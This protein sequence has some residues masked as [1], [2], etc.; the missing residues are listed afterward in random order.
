MTAWRE[1]PSSPRPKENGKI[2]VAS[3]GQILV[4][5]LA[6]R[7]AH[8]QLARYCQWGREDER[9]CRYRVTA[10]SLARARAQ[11]LNARKLP[12]VLES[13]GASPIPPAVLNF[14]QNWEKFGPQARFERQVLLRVTRARILD[15][16]LA[17]PAASSLGERLNS[18]TILVKPGREQPVLDQLARL[19]YLAESRLDV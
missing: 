19:G 12:A 4:A 16:L 6:P 7:V 8:Y 11:G 1:S 9:G 2:A 15:E 17:S 10:A 3:T 5:P 13:G 18:E 14:I